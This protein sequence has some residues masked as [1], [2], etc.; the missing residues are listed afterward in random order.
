[1]VEYTAGS[2]GEV[3]GE[4]KPMIRDIDG[5]GDGDGS[6]SFF[7]LADFPCLIMKLKCFLCLIKYHTMNTY[8]VLN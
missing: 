4:R 3:P 8:P 6:S 5:D 7:F 1:V 2:K